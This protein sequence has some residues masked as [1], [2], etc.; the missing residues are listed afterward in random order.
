MKYSSTTEISINS[1]V[2][3]NVVLIVNYKCRHYFFLNKKK[4]K[5][6]VYQELNLKIN[7]LIDDK[8]TTIENLVDLIKKEG[9]LDDSLVQKLTQDFKLKYIK[10]EN[11]RIGFRSVADVLKISSRY[12]ALYEDLGVRRQQII[13]YKKQIE[14]SIKKIN[15]LTTKNQSLSSDTET[16]LSEKQSLL[17]DK[18]LLSDALNKHKNNFF[19]TKAKELTEKERNKTPK[20]TEVINHLN[21]FLNRETTY[22]E[23]GVRNPN[24]NFNKINATKKY[25]VDPGVEF[26]E[27]PVDFKM[28][29]DVFF[30]NLSQ[31]KILENTKFDIIFID[32]LHIST[33]VDR[34]IENSLKFLKEDGFVVLHDCNPPTE[35]H[36]RETFDYKYSPAKDSWNGTTW[37]AFVKYRANKDVYSC[38]VDTDW[39]VGIISKNIN[40]GSHLNLDNL[41]FY[42]YSNL[43]SKRKEILNLVS[44]NAFKDK[45]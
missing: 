13:E 32:G 28:T 20:R 35:W 27:N 14:A 2:L 39:G 44:F 16:L 12:N 5:K 33:Q 38:C 24:D 25:S 10:E 36:A 29:S 11:W 7:D 34:D 23:I 19:N 17:T 1:T 21:S 3:K 18:G 6:A 31:K 30:E 15:F 37:K 4:I 41:S 42:E 43:A 45:L 9:V 40:L 26:E 8:V 22:L